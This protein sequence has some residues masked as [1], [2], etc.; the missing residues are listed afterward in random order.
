MINKYVD[1]RKVRLLTGHI[2]SHQVIF[3][4]ISFTMSADMF[5]KSPVVNRTH[6]VTSGMKHDQLVHVRHK[7][8]TEKG[9]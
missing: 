3:R 2:Q 6:S 4:T 7:Y 1:D 8:E 9:L 5:K